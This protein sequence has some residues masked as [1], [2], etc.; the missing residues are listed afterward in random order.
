MSQPELWRSAFGMAY[1]SVSEAKHRNSRSTRLRAALA[2]GEWH[3]GN[4]LAGA[5]GWRFGGA[6][7]RIRKGRDGLPVWEVLS[8][9]LE[10]DGSRWRYRWTGRTLEAPQL[11]KKPRREE[12][13]FSALTRLVLAVAR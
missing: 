8:E 6:L 13:L 9:R 4:E 2:D 5:S 3:F 7:E 11:I 1:E 10:E 12:E